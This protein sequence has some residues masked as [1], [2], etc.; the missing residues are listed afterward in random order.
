[1]KEESALELISTLS[2]YF[3][4]GNSFASIIEARKFAEQIGGERIESGTVQA[5]HLDEIV[6]SALTRAAT[7]IVSDSNS[8]IEVFD[9]LIN[10]Y[11]H[12]PS[13]NVKTS[14]SVAQQA[15]ST[16]IPIAYLAA[17]LAGIDETKTVY[18]PTG[19]HGSLL[20]KAAKNLVQVN[21][22]NPERAHDLIAQG[23]SVTQNDAI[24]YT[25]TDKFD[26]VILNP[27]F[28]TIQ[29]K[30]GQTKRF[31]IEAG[32]AGRP[33]QTWQTTQ[34]DHVI[35]LRSLTAMKTDG[36]AVLIL[37]GKLGQ[38]EK[39]RSN[40]YNTQMSR[41]FYQTLY[42]NYKVTKHISI[43]GNLY[44]K[45]GAGFPID[46]IV[47]D[48]IGKSNR[49]L[50]ASDIPKIYTS[51][52][53][54]KELF[55]E[56]A[57]K[58]TNQSQQSINLVADTAR[59]SQYP[60]RNLG[61]SPSEN[62]LNRESNSLFGT[63]EISGVWIDS[64]GT[65]DNRRN[66]SLP[67][68]ANSIGYEIPQLNS[69]L[70]QEQGKPTDSFFLGE[71]DN[72]G[73]RLPLGNDELRNENGVSRNGSYFSTESTGEHLGAGFME[74]ANNGDELRFL[75][76][77]KGDK[78]MAEEI[79]NNQEETP[80][81]VAYKPGSG[82]LSLNT[83]VPTNLSN[84]TQRSLSRLTQKV[85]P[86]V[87]KFY[88]LRGIPVPENFEAKDIIDTFVME[89][90]D[91]LDK[92]TLYSRFS[93][94]Q[95]DAGALFISTVLEG[96]TFIQGDQTGIGKGRNAAL[97]IDWAIK[98]GMTPIFITQS[99]ELHSAM[100]SDLADIGRGN[101][102]PFPTTGERI[103]TPN[104]GVIKL[105][106]TNQ[107][108]L[109][110]QF[111]QSRSLGNQYD[112]IVTT[113]SQLQ[114]VKG[115]E[116][117]RHEFLRNIAPN[118][119]IIMDECHN[120]VGSRNPQTQSS[121]AR[122]ARELLNNSR[123]GLLLSATS[124]KDANYSLY[125]KTDMLLAVDGNVA[126]LD[127]LAARGGIPMMQMVSVG[128]ASSGQYIRR[129]RSYEGV[130]VGVTVAEIDL[131][132]LDRIYSVMADIVRFDDIKQEGI[133]AQD[134]A[135]KAEA[136]AVLNDDSVGMA[137]ADSSNFTAIMHN[138]SSQLLLAAKA[139]TSV[140]WAVKQREL[141]KKPV[142]SL[143]NTMGSAIDRYVEEKGLKSGDAIDIS[144][145]DLLKHYAERSREIRTRDAF[146]SQNKRRLT[147]EEIG[148]EGVLVWDEIMS[149][150]DNIDFSS[151]P[152]SP[153]D[154]ISNRLQQYGIKTGEVTG[155]SSQINYNENPP[156]Y[157]VR[158]PKESSAQG[159]KEAVDRFN[160]GRIDAIILNSAGSTGISLHASEKFSDKS[161]RVM[162]ILQADPKITG[163]MQ[164]LGRIHRTGQVAL[165]EFE[166]ISTS[167]PAEV[168][169]TAVLLKK[170]AAL[171]ANT[172][173][174][175][176]SAF[177]LDN[178]VDFLNEYGDQIVAEILS[179]N[180][181]INEKLDYPLDY[182]ADNYEPGDDARKVTGRAILL[183]IEE[184]KWFL[185]TLTE[186]YNELVAQMEA[187]GESTLEAKSVDLDARTLARM[188]VK[189]A[190]IPGD[191]PFTEAVYLEV[192][193]AKTPVKPYTQLQ[194]V[195]Q[196]RSALELEPVVDI[197]E[198][199][200]YGV[201]KQGEESTANIKSEL[202]AALEEYRTLATKNKSEK[203]IEKINSALDNNYA[204]ISKVLDT[205][206]VGQTVRVLTGQNIFYGVVT[207]IWQTDRG[208]DEIEGRISNP[209]APSN[210][211]VKLAIA[212]TARELSVPMSKINQSSESSIWV[213]PAET[214]S[215]KVNI[216]EIFDQR[217]SKSREQR[218]IFT[219][220]IIRAYTMFNGS[221]RVINFTDNKGNVRQGILMPKGFDIQ[222]S[223]EAEPVKMPSI[224]DAE[225]FITTETNYLGHVKTE[226]G[227]LK[228][229][230][231][232]NQQGYML[233]TPI[234]KAAG[235]GYYLDKNL[236]EACG[237]EFTSIG[238]VMRVMV[239]EERIEQVLDYLISVQQHTLCAFEQREEAR[240]MLGIELPTMEALEAGTFGSSGDFVP[241]VDETNY[242]Q[243]K[244]DL[245]K[246]FTISE[247]QLE[248]SSAQLEPDINELDSPK[249]EE[250]FQQNPADNSS[251]TIQ[252]SSLI[253]TTP[254]SSS[255]Q[256][257]EPQTEEKSKQ[258][259][260][261]TKEFVRN[262]TNP[263]IRA[264]LEGL[265]VS[266]IGFGTELFDTNQTAKLIEIFEQ[267]ADYRQNLESRTALERNLTNA[268]LDMHANWMSNKTAHQVVLGLIEQVELAQV[269]YE[270]E[271]YKDDALY[272]T[273]FW[274]MIQ[275]MSKI[276]SV[277]DERAAEVSLDPRL[278]ALPSEEVEVLLETLLA[279]KLTTNT[280]QQLHQTAP[281]AA[282]LL[283]ENVAVEA[284]TSRHLA[285]KS[286]NY[287]I[288]T[289]DDTTHQEL[290]NGLYDV[291]L[292]HLNLKPVSPVS[293]EFIDT[294]VT[295]SSPSSETIT[296][297]INIAS[298]QQ[299]K[300]AGAKKVATLL[301][302]SGLVAEIMKGDDFHLKVEN[303]PYIPLVIERHGNELYLTHYLEQGGDTFIDSEMVYRI[304]DDGSLK[305]KEVATQNPFTGGEARSHDRGF[306]QMFSSN[307]IAQGFAEA[308][309]RAW[310]SAI[311]DRSDIPASIENEFNE[312]KPD[313]VT[314]EPEKVNELD[315]RAKSENIEAE[316]IS[317]EKSDISTLTQPIDNE[318]NYF[319]SLNQLRLWYVQA[320]DL[321]RDSSYLEQIKSLGEQMKACSKEAV[322]Y[323][324][325]SVSD[326]PINVETQ[327]A[328]QADFDAYRQQTDYIFQ[329]T[330]TILEKLGKKQGAAQ[331]FEGKYYRL[332]ATNDTAK[333]VEKN[334]GE[335]LI[336]DK[337]Q[338]I[339]TKVNSTDQQKFS[340]LCVELTRN[341]TPD[342]GQER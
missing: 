310:T 12:Q 225:R 6:E 32:A 307:L 158:S 224:S 65:D 87:E 50:P 9:R 198:H 28:G 178:T 281:D 74:L 62:T 142:L 165:P 273:P 257:S 29:D 161:I 78:R 187:I 289:S 162:G 206:P 278:Q 83:L 85:R 27:P 58:S 118:A 288:L 340:R 203:R 36:K 183:S 254:E 106:N 60:D 306:A 276:D 188:E 210:W 73:Q 314:G 100:M 292:T 14:T 33:G 126:A 3:Y 232:P 208:A 233:S 249:V 171:N 64:S 116:T 138:L 90:L 309:A 2:D 25:P 325:R 177:S 304:G 67:K 17:T 334:R 204:H 231:R 326:F 287:M 98:H 181:R 89:Q 31:L 193:D 39:T 275:T 339:L 256:V 315:L 323:P 48:G 186:R 21:E 63:T 294:S 69:P 41:A 285:T 297:Q 332:E 248:L 152:V 84:A 312:Q 234:S 200:F 212:D 34:L 24:T 258:I 130:E 333:V 227:I 40:R 137:G 322:Q 316:Q 180:P 77:N 15:Y 270:K 303:N 174:T 96:K 341:N 93:A 194:C 247:A 146:G 71:S 185:D 222:K 291:Y 308:T 5:K 167:A 245:E 317:E 240:K 189:P 125:A 122:F 145:G 168:R 13:L 155:R 132:V 148:S 207:K 159:R 237:A 108:Q 305:L 127:A 160:S 175:R 139:E 52:A 172:T 218:Q 219:G 91:I 236:I 284:I 131:S 336:V 173:A 250:V 221:G 97:A 243:T 26:V 18:E 117:S 37:G 54:L 49:Q 272:G 290:I 214:D 228:I 182:D 195:N 299:Q 235:G 111:T 144:F 99:P 113:Y 107:K 342:R 35:A 337:N 154:Y 46:L 140:Q 313:F 265:A 300:E 255:K 102:R 328:M 22:L 230:A 147:D 92:E 252:N 238:D 94:E 213:E 223:L 296:H 302:K 150:I 277:V 7:R 136:K 119:L 196:V 75:N 324:D 19:G 149:Q 217:Q 319:T 104:N 298:P 169:P 163:F 151:L 88:E 1:M 283:F 226:D 327:T 47:I 10:L 259:G 199:D 95:I 124:M 53:Q 338:I 179:E 11:Q 184:Q 16:P 81:Q 264:K 157:E 8:D 109:M 76:R 267:H 251:E 320:R 241:Y 215:F 141:G 262:A 70:F 220:N 166:F 110:N 335:I 286:E 253:E 114:N 192:I 57:I 318:P 246:L 211:K 205:M 105:S 143:Y 239:P 279:N 133:K 134:K 59:R 190:D 202:R 129:E 80:L 45:Q 242:E 38:N 260:R 103:D 56:S 271:L 112:F 201:C 244:L 101:L 115:N 191:S 86:Q 330:H 4:T 321:G 156:T 82:G 79:E 128:L 269:A 135:L 170:L 331:V 197:N 123:G 30:N 261:R 66:G 44:R 216:Y 61:N 329:A 229:Q 311:A 268:V 51:F 176:Q 42:N 121:R 280:V 209:A 301:H 120:A 293:Q 263:Y 43:D 72:A 55:N 164:M 68:D 153:I 274:S 282:K 266:S 23:F 20:I 295:E